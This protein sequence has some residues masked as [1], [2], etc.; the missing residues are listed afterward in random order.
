MNIR[1]L[2]DRIAENWAAKVVC[3][4]IAFLLYIFYRTSTLQE[5]TFTIPLTVQAEGLMMP[6]SDLPKYIKLSVKTTQENMASIKEK[7]FSAKINLD[8]F[9]EAGEYVVPVVVSASEELELLD[10]FECR[11]KTEYFN[12]ILD[13]KILKY[14]PVEVAQS[15]NPAYGYSVEEFDVSPATVKVVGPSRIVEKTSKIYTKKVI[16]GGAATSFSKDVKL[17]NINSKITLLPESDFKVT[18]KIVPTEETRTYEKIVP[19]VRNLK[20]N[21][22][23][24]NF[25]A[26]ISVQAAGTTLLLDSLSLSSGSVYI[27]LSG[28]NEPGEYELPVNIDIPAGIT[29]V[30][31][32]SENVVVKISEKNISETAEPLNLDENENSSAE[33]KEIPAEETVSE[34]KNDEKIQK[35]QKV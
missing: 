14:I 35:E 27:D 32:S 6:V 23:V 3:L 30:S 16:I 13:E 15:G 17:D 11:P 26:E 18:V 19:S 9:V 25:S 33:E 24:E 1:K 21:L 31:R 20:E 5:K 10:V 4:I 2:I 34:E 29:I 8:N 28:I 7:D 12:V 22:E